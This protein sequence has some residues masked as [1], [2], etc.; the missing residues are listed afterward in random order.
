MNNRQNS[1]NINCD[2]TANAKTLSNHWKIKNFFFY[3]FFVIGEKYN[4]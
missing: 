4:L 2:D 1:T 3:S